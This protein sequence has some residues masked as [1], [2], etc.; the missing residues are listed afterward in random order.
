MIRSGGNAMSG[1]SISLDPV[2]ELVDAYERAWRH[3][4]P[5]LDAFLAKL[6]DEDRSYGLAEL[7][8]IELQ[9]LYRRSCR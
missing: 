3:G 5:S 8:K 9:E 2:A 7:I 1:P 4:R 6:D